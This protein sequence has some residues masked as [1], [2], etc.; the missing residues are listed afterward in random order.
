MPSRSRN[1]SLTISLI[2]LAGPATA[3]DLIIHGG[4]I[5]TGQDTPS[6]VEAVVVEDRRIVF[7]GPH[8]QAMD[9]RKAGTEIIDLDGAVMYPGFTDAHAHLLGIGLRE[10]TL[11]LED[12]GSIAELRNR[13]AKAVAT[14]PPGETIF[15][16]GWIE[17]HW[18]E[19]R[20]P[21]REDLD[22]VSPETPVF[23]VRADGHAAVVNSAGL[24]AAGINA[25]TEAPFGGEILSGPDGEPTGMLID[26]AMDLA[27]DLQPDEKSVDRREAYAR[28]NAVYTERGW[29]GLHNMSVPWDDVPLL[30]RL[31]ETGVMELRIYNAIDR[32]GA[33]ALLAEGHRESRTGR[34]MTRAIKLY[35]DGALGS[36]GA[37]LLDPYADAEGTGLLRMKKAEAMPLLNRALREGIQIAT[38][39]IGDKANRLALDWFAEA[40]AAV[41]SETRAITEPRWRIE[42]AQILDPADIPRFEKLGVIASMQPSHAI[43]DLHFAPDRLGLERLKGAY[44]WTSLVETGAIIAAGSDAP[45]EKGDP[46]EEFY[47]AVA[48]KDLSGFSGPG[49]HPEQ[50]VD[51]ATALKM[52]T[53]WPAYAA[54]QADELGSIEVGKR[55]DFTVFSA[56]IMRIP[57]AEIPKAQAVLTVIDGKVVFQRGAS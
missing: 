13:V 10:M 3:A 31:S 33:E 34:V 18:P 25:E 24:A 45:V 14:T 21:T 47:A 41:P 55:A 43:G 52:F 50:A 27:A 4:P 19:E 49:W 15:G 54:F 37:L 22:S 30:E 42:H 36:R 40:L 6:T 39:A 56:D 46:L 28:A 57:E 2:A 12:V 7:I 9:R 32:S 1:L 51:R 11:N 26:D 17:T 8:D 16:R 53:R 29:T 44:A 5:Y 48:R 35:M 23:L 38:H 20:F